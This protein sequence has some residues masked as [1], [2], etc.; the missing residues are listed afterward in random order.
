MIHARTIKIWLSLAAAICVLLPQL[1]FAVATDLS[2]E[3]AMNRSIEIEPGSS[4]QTGD[5]QMFET[6]FDGSDVGLDEVEKKEN[7]DGSVTFNFSMPDD[8]WEKRRHDFCNLPGVVSC[9]ANHCREYLAGENSFDGQVRSIQGGPVAGAKIALMPTPPDVSQ[10]VE[11]EEEEDDEA[12]IN[13][14][15]RPGKKR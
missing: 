11:E 3:P 9:G 8:D 10:F 13:L 1:A 2:L 4:G 14:N 7:S 12:G 5:T 6:F 15:M